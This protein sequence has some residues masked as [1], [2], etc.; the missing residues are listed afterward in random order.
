MVKHTHLP[1]I[2]MCSLFMHDLALSNELNSQHSYLLKGYSNKQIKTEDLHVASLLKVVSMGVKNI[3]PVPKKYEWLASQVVMIRSRGL[4]RST[5]FVTGRNCNIVLSSA[6]GIIDK[7]GRKAKD[8]YV[9]LNPYDRPNSKFVKLKDIATGWDYDIKR[10]VTHFEH[11]D[12]RE[13]WAVS[14]G[15]THILDSCSIIRIDKDGVCNGKL[16]LISYSR[17]YRRKVYS[18]DKQC[19]LHEFKKTEQA[20]RYGMDINSPVNVVKHSCDTEPASSGSPLFCEEKG[21]ITL[22]G[23]NEGYH[24]DLTYYSGVDK[25]STHGQDYNNEDY[26]N[27]AVL[28]DGIFK[29]EYERRINK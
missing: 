28:I 11:N 6:H 8:V 22:I 5:G 24:D 23:V 12:P 17:N 15:E 9:N 18:H 19:K 29:K 25:L 2:I 13:D 16:F 1:I 14:E 21:N 3:T 7:Y 4:G 26:F 10:A 20:R 27:K